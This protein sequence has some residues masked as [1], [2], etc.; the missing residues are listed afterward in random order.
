M[1]RWF[2]LNDSTFSLR[3]RSVFDLDNAHEFNHAQERSILDGRFKFDKEGRYAVAFHASSGKYFN[4][5]YADFM[6][7]GNKQA[8]LAEQAKATPAVQVKFA[9]AE[10]LDAANYLASQS[11]GGWSFYVRQLY[12][13]AEPIKGVELQYGGLDINR[14]VASEMTTYDNDGYISGERI[15]LKRPSNLFFDE[16]SVTYAYLGDLFKPNFFARGERL[17][18][19]NYHQFLVRRHVGKRV[20]SSFDYT[21]QSAAN[22]L[23]EDV[24]VKVPET[25]VIDS[26]RVEF[27][28]RLNGIY[29]PNVPHTATFYRTGGH[30]FGFTASKKTKQ[31]LFE[32][33]IVNI[34]EQSAVLTQVGVLGVTGLAMNADQFGMGN[35]YFVRPSIKLTPYL[36]LT[37]YYT[38]LYGTQTD[39]NQ[40]LWDKQALNAGL[41]FDLK[42]AL[43]PTKRAQ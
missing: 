11:S 3:Y 33:G 29:Y 40:L 20:D 17:A 26:V 23:H 7:G 34:D 6:G 16:A 27:Y 39:P 9:R 8:F 28:Q 15:V 4:W 32:A 43:L 14:G 36:D 1:D 2:T 13:D 38:H 41:V 31:G 21:W 5:A 30:G 12:F 22:M 10:T 35:R 37:G 19:S 24:F 42:K 18:H 25:R